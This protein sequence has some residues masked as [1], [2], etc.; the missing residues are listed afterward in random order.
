MLRS[1]SQD[2]PPSTHGVQDCHASTGPAINFCLSDGIE[3]QFGKFCSMYVLTLEPEC[4]VKKFGN[5][6]AWVGPVMS[7]NIRKQGMVKF[8][9]Y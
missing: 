2:S 7:G 4:D 5:S 1:F 9:S 6:L 3:A 8:S